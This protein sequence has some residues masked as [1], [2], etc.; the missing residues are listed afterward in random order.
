[1][2]ASR[3]SIRLAGEALSSSGTLVQFARLLYNS[4]TKH[5]CPVPDAVG[6]FDGRR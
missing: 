4:K 1:M 5:G 6:G 3:S 2:I